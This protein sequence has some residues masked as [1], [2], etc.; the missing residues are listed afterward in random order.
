MKGIASYKQHSVQDAPPEDILVMLLEK[1]LQKEDQADEA[2][3]AGD[4]VAWNAAL[5]HTRA[6][7]MELALALDASVAPD[8]AQS[9]GSAYRWAIHHLTECAHTGDRAKLAQVREVTR[10]LLETWSA[11]VSQVRGEEG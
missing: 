10:Q 6:I 5:H 4:R 9:V 1:A 11:A 8:V 7:F 3:A 2:M